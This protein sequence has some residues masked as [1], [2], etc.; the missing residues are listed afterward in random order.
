MSDLNDEEQLELFKQGNKNAYAYIYVKH[1]QAIFKYNLDLCA[2]KKLAKDITQEVFKRVWDLREQMTSC[3]HLRACLYLIANQ[4]FVQH[5]LGGRPAFN[6]E[7]DLAYVAEHQE[8]MNEELEVACNH[9]LL[10]VDAGFKALSSQRRLVL[11]LLYIKGYDKATVA[12]ML[13]ITPQTVTNTKNYAINQLRA[14][15][16]DGNLL[17]PLILTALLLYLE[18]G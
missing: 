9:L 13:N 11:E 8:T 1:N 5:L 7:K 6:P 14:M 4:L 15:L 12:G 18:E 2:D 16:H 17:K 3:N 10:A